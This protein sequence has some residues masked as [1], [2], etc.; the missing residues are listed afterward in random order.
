ML[1]ELSTGIQRHIPQSQPATDVDKL[2]RWIIHKTFT[3]TPT[4][5]DRSQKFPSVLFS[6][7]SFSIF[8]FL[9]TFFRIFLKKI[10]RFFIL[11]F[12]PIFHF[13]IFSIFF[14][15]SFFR[16]FFFFRFFVFFLFLFS[17]SP[18]RG[19]PKHRFSNKNMN[20]KERF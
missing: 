14:I 11:Q 4:N 3:V 1:Q 20:F 13:F 5:A 7:I 15:S 17:V 16:I 2:N 10:V 12:S 8:S 18:T 19:L 6:L 9:S